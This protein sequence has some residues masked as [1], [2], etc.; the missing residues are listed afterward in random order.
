MIHDTKHSSVELLKRAAN[1]NHVRRPKSLGENK[2]MWIDMRSPPPGAG[3]SKV[4][5]AYPMYI[6]S[7][8][9]TKVCEH[10]LKTLSCFILW[11]KKIHQYYP[12]H[13]WNC[14]GFWKRE[15]I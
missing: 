15:F 11:Q 12:P 7:A 9:N 8:G 6:Q 14:N 3:T 13:F 10:K 1:Q 2:T 5:V 4:H